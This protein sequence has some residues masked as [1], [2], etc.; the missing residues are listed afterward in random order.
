M[1]RPIAIS[2]SPNTQK[3]DVFLALR[4]LL[5]PWRW[6]KGKTPQALEQAFKRYLGQKYAFSVSSGRAALY[7]ALKALGVGQGDEVLIQGFTC[8]SVPLA[9]L[10]TGAKPCY[11]DIDETFNLDPEDLVQKITP[12]SKVVIL[13]HSFG[14][15][16]QIKKILEIARK[17]NL[18][19]LEDCAHSLGAEHKGQKIGTFGKISIFS[20]GRDKVLS[21][22]F[23][24]MITT[25]DRKLARTLEK[26]C[27]SFTYPSRRWIFE[28]LFHPVVFELLVLPSYY[29]F[30][31]GKIF[32]VLF[33]KGGLVSRVI[34]CREKRGQKPEFL[35]KKMPNALA[36]LALFQFRRLENFNSHRRKIASFYQR[37]LKDI[38]SIKL[39]LTRKDSKPIFLRF[40]ILVPNQKEILKKAKKHH[41]ILG[42]WYSQVVAPQYVDLEMAGYQKGSCPRAERACQ[43]VINLPTHIN[44]EKRQAEKITK[45]LISYLRNVT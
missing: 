39:P 5:W 33:Q 12:R 16:A 45:I 38:K 15:P 24:G 35:L 13:Q 11:I 4:L 43:K 22:V 1:F 37:K 21:S 14:Q 27:S 18:T 17:Y 3:K 19:I 36:V 28:Q 26:I 34:T 41:I 23:G 30:S 42:D 9:V 6:Q 2:L 8:L 25:N 40:S 44:I 20:F 31:L 7:L 10:W 29:F 32:L